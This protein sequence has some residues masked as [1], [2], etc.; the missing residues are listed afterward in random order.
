VFD[1]ATRMAFLTFLPFV[2]S[3]KGASLPTVGLALTLVFA[4]G[5]A[6]KLVCAFIGARIGVIGTVWLTEALTAATIIALLPLPLE[7]ALALL[8]LLGIA[9]NGTSSVLYGSVP[10]L[11]AP[12]R[13]SRAFGIFY[14]GTIGS[15]ATAPILFGVAGDAF[16]VTVAV[17][18]VAVLALATLPL[19]AMLRPALAQHA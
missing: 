7:P 2:L 6:G 11:V 16:G 18:M 19:A 1:S 17:V 12:E 5:A 15:G 3:A 10:F 13:R 4:G 8:P 14:T 9:L